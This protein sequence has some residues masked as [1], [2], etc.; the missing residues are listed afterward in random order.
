MRRLNAIS[1]IVAGGMIVVICVL[2]VAQIVARL[3][4]FVLPGADEF[5]IAAFV[6]ARP[7]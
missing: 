5:A 7:G 3:F 4:G 1:G 2:I 6:A